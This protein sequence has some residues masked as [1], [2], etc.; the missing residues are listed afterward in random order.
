MQLVVEPAGIADGVPV[1]VPSPERG[2]GGGENQKL[3]P[4]S[5]TTLNT[6]RKQFNL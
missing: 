3:G 1:G 5:G 2:G 4:D 6:I